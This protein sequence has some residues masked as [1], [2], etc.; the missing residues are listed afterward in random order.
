MCVCVDE[1]VSERL[2]FIF[3]LASNLLL[4]IHNVTVRLNVWRFYSTVEVLL[5]L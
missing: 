4:R 5:W 1:C 2:I 3:P